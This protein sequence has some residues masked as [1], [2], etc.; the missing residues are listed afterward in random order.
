MNATFTDKPLRVLHLEDD[1]D[2]AALV[3]EILD[4]E[5]IHAETIPVSDFPQFNAALE[6]ESFDII[7]A[8]Y[9]LPSGNGMQALEAA[10]QID[11]GP[12]ASWRGP[13]RLYANVERAYREFRNEPADAAW[14]TAK[15]FDAVYSVAKAKG[16]EV[17]F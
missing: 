16:I 3:A 12:Y 9:L 7:L 15:T 1:P 11:L 10:K 8:D 17:E 5:G 2:F 13:A 6:R 4:K 14:D